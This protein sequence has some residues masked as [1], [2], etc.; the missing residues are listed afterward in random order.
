MVDGAPDIGFDEVQLGVMAGSY[1]NHSYSH[2]RSGV[3]NP[4]VPDEQQTRFLF[5]RR[6]A[7]VTGLALANRTLTLRSNEIVAGTSFRAWT[8]PPGSLSSPTSVSGPPAGY[9]FL[10]TSVTSSV[11]WMGGYSATV[12]APLAQPWP[13]WQ[14][15]PGQFQFQLTLVQ[16]PADDEGAGFASWVNVQPVITATGQ[17]A[18]LGSMQPEFR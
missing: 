10:Y 13:N 7:P 3:L 9:Q 12:P 17:P 16:L 15:A 11:P 5:L 4:F 2:N 18:L 1:A 8:E 6:T 14:G